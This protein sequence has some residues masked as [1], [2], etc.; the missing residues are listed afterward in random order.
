MALTIT[1]QL[2]SHLGLAADADKETVKSTIL[3]RLGSGELTHD[4]LTELQKAAPSMAD[5]VA[6]EVEKRLKAQAAAQ[7]TETVD[8]NWEE[9]VNN[10]K[11]LAHKPANFVGDDG[12]DHPLKSYDIL[13][14]GA[15]GDKNPTNIRVKAAVERWSD[16][17]KAAT[18]GSKHFQ[19]DHP[20][21]GMP[22]THEGEELNLPS[23]R[24][25]AM[26][27]VWFKT[28]MA[29]DIGFEKV[30]LTEQDRDILM[31]TLHN[32]K[33]YV[34]DVKCDGQSPPP[35]RKLTQAEI[36]NCAM[37]RLGYQKAPLI[38]TSTSGGDQAVP[39]FFDVNLIIL[40]VLGNQVGPYV[41]MVDV[42]RGIA[43]HTFTMSNPTFAYAPEGSATTVFDATGFIAAHDTTFYRAAG[44]FQVGLNFLQDAI[45]TMFEEIENAYSRK[46]AEWVDRVVCSGNG[47]Q[48][49]LGIFSDSSVTVVS[50][51]TPTNGPWVIGDFINLFAG[52]PLSYKM[53]YKPEQMA[54]FGTETTYFR[55]RSIATGVTGDTR[56]VFGMDIASYRLFNTHYGVLAYSG[57]ANDQVGFAQLGGY[58]LYRRQGL[59]FRRET[60]GITLLQ[61]N[62]IA[63]GADM[64]F[65]G[66]LDRGGY[67]ACIFNG[68]T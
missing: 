12:V 43:A 4:K 68:K 21:Y 35:A 19:P 38:S 8:D 48:E 62:T 41:N 32:E 22:M 13:K 7:V 59:K 33:F 23:V 18:W 46:A 1:A 54:Y 14:G 15:G 11:S 26:T 49:P 50:A 47:T 44:V 29:M 66:K 58:R 42:P 57:A 56:L 40:P 67:A 55:A 34:D 24:R 60:A 51:T 36:H 39:Q 6:A 61:S 17:T 53:M 20:M 63:I 52:V 64:R 30:K 25:K 45:P 2:R 10:A 65:G 16:S 28:D 5:M 37:A 3:S 31:W 27:A 9:L